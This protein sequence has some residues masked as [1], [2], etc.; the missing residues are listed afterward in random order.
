MISVLPN[1]ASFFLNI[2]A[3]LNLL[4]LL[5]VIL[6]FLKNKSVLLSSL[7]HAFD[8]QVI[9]LLESDP[10]FLIINSHELVSEIGSLLG[11]SFVL[12]EEQ[13]ILLVKIKE[14]F[15]PES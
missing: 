2:I 13:F 6:H 1:P 5:D 4:V 9:F 10:I 15:L 14:S 8:Q 7:T 12:L 11:H 3:V